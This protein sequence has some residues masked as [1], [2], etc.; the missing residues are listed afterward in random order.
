MRT[1]NSLGV[2]PSTQ[3]SMNYLPPF[4][5]EDELHLW[6]DSENDGDN[7]EARHKNSGKF[8]DDDDGSDKDNGL[9][10]GYESDNVDF[11]PIQSL[12][13]EH[14]FRAMSHIL[15]GQIFEDGTDPV[16]FRVGMVFRNMKSF[17]WAF[18]DLCIQ[19]DFLSR[20]MKIERRILLYCCYTFKC[21]FQGICF[22]T[23]TW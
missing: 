15:R 18:Q 21:P 3:T 1:R 16:E 19:E 12:D 23:K 10:G 4:H 6:S 11:G 17:A 20:K 13:N 8:D 14:P 2:G 5:A 9:L 22:I 7:E